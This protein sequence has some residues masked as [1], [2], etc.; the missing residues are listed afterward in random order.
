MEVP[1]SDVLFRENVYPS[2]EIKIGCE[3]APIKSEILSKVGDTFRERSFP[4]KLNVSSVSTPTIYT[5][6]D[7]DSG[8]T[9]GSIVNKKEMSQCLPNYRDERK[10]IAGLNY[11]NRIN[12]IEQIVDETISPES[13]LVVTELLQQ[14]SQLS[15]KEKLL[16]YLKLPAGK[17]VLDP[18]RLPL[19]PL[20][21]R[22]EICQ[23]ITWI[24]THLEEDPDVSLPKQDVYDEYK[25]YCENNKVKP[26]STADF[27]KVMKQVFPS[28]RPR[29]LG[30]RGNSRYCYAGLR[31]RR[32]LKPPKLPSILDDIES[33]NTNSPLNDA[34]CAWANKILSTK[35]TTLK[36]LGRYILSLG[37][38]K[39][40]RNSTLVSCIEVGTGTSKSV[41][42]CPSCLRI[43]PTESP[44]QF[45][46][47][48][49]KETKRKFQ[50][51]QSASPI[52]RLQIKVK[53]PEV[54]RPKRTKI[55][56]PKT[57]NRKGK[58][59]TLSNSSIQEPSLAVTST[60]SAHQSAP[61]CD[62]IN[63]HWVKEDLLCKK[64]EQ[65][66][67]INDLKPG[68]STNKNL[69]PTKE[70]SKHLHSECKIS[71]KKSNDSNNSFKLNSSDHLI[72]E[73]ENLV[74]EKSNFSP[75]R[76]MGNGKVNNDND[77]SPVTQELTKFP[78]PR[79]PKQLGNKQLAANI[80]IL[81]AAVQQQAK[82]RQYKPIQPRPEK[83][84]SQEFKKLTEP[85]CHH[86]E[87][88]PNGNSYLIKADDYEKIEHKSS[89]KFGEVSIGSLEKD[90]V[91]DFLHDD[92][93]SQEQ[94]EELLRYF[95]SSVNNDILRVKEQHG[96]SEKL[97][98]LRLLLEKNVNSNP[99][100]LMINTNLEAGN[101]NSSTRNTNCIAVDE[102]MSDSIGC[103]NSDVFIPGQIQTTSDF[104]VSPRNNVSNKPNLVLP[105][106][107]VANSVIQTRRRVSFENLPDTVPPSPNTR[108]QVFN[109]TPISPR[110]YSPTKPKPSASESP[111]VSPR[112]TPLP[113]M[114]YQ[115]NSSICTSQNNHSSP[116]LPNITS[117]IKTRNSP[118]RLLSRSASVSSCPSPTP[119]L[120]P[121]SISS[122]SKLSEIST[123]I[124]TF[125]NMYK[126]KLIQ[127]EGAQS[128]STLSPAK[129]NTNVVITADSPATTCDSPVFNFQNKISPQLV[130]NIKEEA[131]SPPSTQIPSLLQTILMSRKSGDCSNI[132]KE[133][134]G[135][136]IIPSELTMGSIKTSDPLSP[137]VSTLFPEDDTPLQ[138]S[139]F[140]P[141]FRSQSVPM[142]SNSVLISPQSTTHPFPLYYSSNAQY[143]GSPV[144]PTPVPSEL[145]DFGGTVNVDSSS[146]Y[147]LLADNNGTENIE[148]GT[149]QNNI[150]MDSA[151]NK[152]FDMIVDASKTPLVEITE[153]S[154]FQQPS[155]SY[156]NTPTPYNMPSNSRDPIVSAFAPNPPIAQQISRSYPSTP[157]FSK[158]LF[159]DTSNNFGIHQDDI[160]S[161]SPSDRQNI[162]I[163]LQNPTE[164]LGL[165]TEDDLVLHNLTA[166]IPGCEDT[167]N[168]LARE[169]TNEVEGSDL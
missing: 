148:P 56:N 25:I 110:P 3:N 154:R 27:G 87:K 128:D 39:P 129:S 5:N 82:P 138:S 122:I 48:Q 70:Q 23:T 80:V 58:K 163:L 79:L 151:M 46:K 144:V 57:N 53:S 59:R 158:S 31:K 8:W 17:E 136:E 21:S 105:S 78:I 47:Y 38:V 168:E 137:E 89:K 44:T 74:R 116:V 63:H 19:N 9:N 51:G 6:K 68:L 125:Q 155:K 139:D 18:L 7:V 145:T 165:L 101:E 1:Q 142:V 73:D 45:R 111:F 108:R 14:I 35:F 146:D 30:T 99:A 65:V 76:E 134:K 94:E 67:L 12:K 15:V 81:P 97:S 104:Q 10:G 16:L 114:K 52:N 61:I 93:N 152:I 156:P 91:N 20:G 166:E 22:S 77:S 100:E 33:L 60:N 118:S 169:V 126:Q 11:E 92:G 24:R 98:Q 2:S 49:E 117:L 66:S 132:Y 121:R 50:D 153:C 88:F 140:P 119:H 130:N 159:S 124:S 106:L 28:V 157:V 40:T 41:S 75:L 34:V 13:H 160:Q 127:T 164:P 109:F 32:Q 36:E 64:N 131:I 149:E 162:N 85:G 71:S 62:N 42:L 37:D 83:S 135:N 54:C 90:T 123:E 96:K 143:S 167:F 115:G 95:Q 141:T 29:R 69:I 86:S 103:S 43:K 102:N 4:N 26:L 84:D 107:L 113:R 147:L 72:T 161:T 133:E 150:L 112:D 120:R 55:S